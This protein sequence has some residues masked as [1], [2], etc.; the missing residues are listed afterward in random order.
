MPPTS[1]RRGASMAVRSGVWIVIALGFLVNKVLTIQH[2]RQQG[3]LVTN[4]DVG[5]VVL[6]MGVL[7]FWIFGAI[8]DWKRRMDARKVV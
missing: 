1:P 7:C 4:W 6:W 2:Y 8:W 3:K 5:V